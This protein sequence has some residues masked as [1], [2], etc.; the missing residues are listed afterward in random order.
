MKHDNN[1]ILILRLIMGICI[2]SHI[3]ILL[4]VLLNYEI[5][6]KKELLT[7]H[8]L[9]FSSMIIAPVILIRIIGEI[10]NRWWLFNIYLPLSP[11]ILLLFVIIDPIIDLWDGESYRMVYNVLFFSLLIIYLGVLVMNLAG[12]KNLDKIPLL[13]SND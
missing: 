7:E 8:L 11:F 4:F 10:F 5:P 9:W 13:N 3:I 2:I 1:W 6:S 12:V